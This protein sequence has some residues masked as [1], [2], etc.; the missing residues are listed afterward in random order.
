MK[1]FNNSLKL[2]ESIIQSFDKVIKYQNYLLLKMI[3]EKSGSN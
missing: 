3:K 1:P 2:D